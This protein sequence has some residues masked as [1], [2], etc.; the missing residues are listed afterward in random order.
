MS[1]DICT[2]VILNRVAERFVVSTIKSL[3]PS[4][5][6]EKVFVKSFIIW[7]IGAPHLCIK[8]GFHVI[9]YKRG[10]VLKYFAAAGCLCCFS[11]HNLDTTKNLSNL[12]NQMILHIT[13]YK[14]D[15]SCHKREGCLRQR[16]FG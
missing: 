7:A 10:Q 4:H 3:L 1:N 12:L 5:Y 9:Y 13:I 16:H 11:I 2:I 15:Y 6:Q 8:K 14:N